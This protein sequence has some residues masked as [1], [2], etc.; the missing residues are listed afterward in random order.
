MLVFFIFSVFDAKMQSN[1][2]SM[3]TCDGFRT[4]LSSRCLLETCKILIIAGDFPPVA[5][6]I[7]RRYF[8]TGFVLRDGGEGLAQSGLCTLGEVSRRGPNVAFRMKSRTESNQECQAVNFWACGRSCSI[9]VSLRPFSLVLPHRI[10]IAV[11]GGSSS[12]VPQNSLL[13]VFV[14]AINVSQKV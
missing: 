4:L 10:C 7:P 3:C 14:W 6:A 5:A 1:S 8:P 9:N 12:S 13:K 2:F 11:A